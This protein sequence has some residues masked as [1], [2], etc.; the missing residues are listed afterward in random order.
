MVKQKNKFR[1][2]IWLGVLIL[3]VLGAYAFWPKSSGKV[4][5]IGVAVAQTGLA[6]EWGQG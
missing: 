5:K 4:I 2:F 3:I 1:F 6:D